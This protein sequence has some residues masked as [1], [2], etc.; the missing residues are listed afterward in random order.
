VFVDLAQEAVLTCRRSL[1]AAADIIG[2]KTDKAVDGRLF[3]V[4][5]LLILKEMTAGLDLGRASRHRDWHGMTDF[6]RALMENVSSLVGYGRS[7]A[8][9]EFAPDAKTV[10]RH[11]ERG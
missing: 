11:F 5:H 6:L 1:S 2:A 7:T 3:L 10:S 9:G 8:R 4:R